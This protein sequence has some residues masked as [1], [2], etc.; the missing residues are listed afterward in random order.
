MAPRFSSFSLVEG[1][2]VTL[3]DFGPGVTSETARRPHQENC[4]S[5]VAEPLYSSSGAVQ[6]PMSTET[7]RPFGL[8]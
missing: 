3:C 1:P 8:T 5:S 6:L 2:Q 7:S 4:F